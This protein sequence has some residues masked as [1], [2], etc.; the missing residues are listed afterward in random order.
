VSW[1]IIA[2]SGD[3]SK[4]REE[5][6]PITGSASPLDGIGRVIGAASAPAV[7]SILMKGSAAAAA[8]KFLRVIM[9]LFLLQQV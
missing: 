7:T 9:L 1:P 4:V 5:P 2:P 8:N 3:T 6:M